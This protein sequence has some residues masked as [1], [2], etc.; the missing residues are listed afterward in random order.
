MVFEALKRA[1]KLFVSYQN[2]PLSGDPNHEDDCLRVF[3]SKKA[4]FKL[5]SFSIRRDLDEL[6]YLRYLLS[7]SRVSL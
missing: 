7:D 4:P 1:L 2:G 3:V 6:A 5:S